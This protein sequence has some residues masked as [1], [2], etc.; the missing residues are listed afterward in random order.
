MNKPL[1]RGK[2][3]CLLVLLCAGIFACNKEMSS[4]SKSSSSSST[5]TTDS[6]SSTIAVVVDSSSS[7][8][9]TVYLLQSCANGTYR[10]SVDSAALPAAILSY[11]DT[12]YAG[13]DFLKGFEIKNHSGT[14]EGYVVVISYDGKPVGLLF[15]ASGTFEG[16]LEQQQ[17]PNHSGHRDRFGNRNSQQ[18]DTVALSALSSTITSWFSSNYSSDTLLKAFENFDSSYV[19]ISKDSGVIYATVFSASGSFVRREVLSAWGGTVASLTSG[20]LPAAITTYLSSAYTGYV[21][22]KAWSLTADGSIQ[23]YLVVIDAND[24]KYSLL[25]S[26]SG[27]LES[28]RTIW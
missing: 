19:V 20:D 26:S 16:V 13:Y 6:T 17:G 21:F 10:D 22:E 18:P 28:A 27:T 1:E 5:T 3:V 7:G 9:D 8:K 11:L 25:F 15:N 4:A 23:D 24:T 14:I 2:S 12:A